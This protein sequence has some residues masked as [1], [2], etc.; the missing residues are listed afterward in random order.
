MTADNGPRRLH[1]GLVGADVRAL[2]VRLNVKGLA[3]IA[4]DGEFGPTTETAVRD[5][6]RRLGIEPSGVVDEPVANLILAYRRLE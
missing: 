5:A 4:A 2:Q 1:R 6:Q 3:R